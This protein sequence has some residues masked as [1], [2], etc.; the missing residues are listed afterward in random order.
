[1]EQEVVLQEVIILGNIQE[2]MKEEQMK[3]EVEGTQMR[4]EAEREQMK[5]EEE[6]SRQEEA[7]DDTEQGLEAVF[8]YGEVWRS[9]YQLR[10]RY[11]ENG[12]RHTNVLA[13]FGHFGRKRPFWPFSPYQF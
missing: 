7:M 6:E 1:M 2:E 8:A 4:E 10:L 3:D 12:F 11:G 9:P 13:S 5:E